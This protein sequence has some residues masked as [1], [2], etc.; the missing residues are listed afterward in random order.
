MGDEVFAVAIDASLQAAAR[1]DWRRA[2]RGADHRI[3]EL[4]PAA[5]ER[6]HALC[7]AY[8]LAFAAI[9]LAVEKGTIWF[10]EINPNG[11]WAWLEE[12]TGIPIARALARLFA[13]YD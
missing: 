10:F 4:E 2:G 6:C 9:D 13:S 1:A 3:V 12:A 7:R 5:C 8:N 11:Q